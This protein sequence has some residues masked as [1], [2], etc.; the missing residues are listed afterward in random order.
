MGDI[1]GTELLKITGATKTQLNYWIRSGA[2]VPEVDVHGSGRRRVYSNRNIT[3]V[4]ICVEL[5]KFG[6][7]PV[8]MKVAIDGLRGKQPN[9]V[10][11]KIFIYPDR[12][13]S[14]GIDKGNYPSMIMVDMA[15]L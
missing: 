14:I 7:S 2:V 8:V 1:G 6:L 5:N 4:G 15:K 11:G 9:E 13:V 12:S 3:E 10:K